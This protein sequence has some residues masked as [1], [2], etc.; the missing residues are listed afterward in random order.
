MKG[1]VA[2]P[3]HKPLTSECREKS[4]QKRERE[5]QERT[6]SWKP[7]RVRI[8]G[9]KAWRADMW[10]GS[11]WPRAGFVMWKVTGNLERAISEDGT[12]E[13]WFHLVEMWVKGGWGVEMVD[14]ALLRRGGGLFFQSERLKHVWRL[15]REQRGREWQYKSKRKIFD[16]V[17][18]L[19]RKR[20]GIKGNSR[21]WTVDTKKGHSLR[22]PPPPPQLGGR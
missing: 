14:N 13:N 6:K 4:N 3:P 20:D 2:F 19:G 9:E 18:S 12:I 10:D 17:L 21:G 5:N 8:W 11:S 15:R 16:G 1:E 7:S 22:P